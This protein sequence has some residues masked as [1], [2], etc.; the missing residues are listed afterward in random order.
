MCLQ[1]RP[2]AFNDVGTEIH[3]LIDEWR[4]AFSASPPPEDTVKVNLT[5]ELLRRWFGDAMLQQPIHISDLQRASVVDFLR[6]LDYPNEY[7][8][9]L[10]RSSPTGDI[11]LATERVDVMDKNALN[12]RLARS[13][14]LELED[15]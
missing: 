5:P 10:T 13:Y 3:A 8:P 2:V 11:P 4:K 1:A 6:L 7:V 14:L 15:A 12:A 9:I